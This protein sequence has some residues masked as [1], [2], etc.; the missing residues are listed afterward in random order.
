MELKNVNSNGSNDVERN[1]NN[2]KK[3]L[4]QTFEN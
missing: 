4:D 1:P 2:V 3:N